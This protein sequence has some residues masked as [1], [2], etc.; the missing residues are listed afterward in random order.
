M[1]GI[2][3]E[4]GQ[5]MN[6]IAFDQLDAPVGPAAYRAGVAS[7]ATTLEYAMLVDS[8]KIVAAARMSWLASRR[9]AGIGVIPASRRRAADSTDCSNGRILPGDRDAGAGSSRRR[10]APS[11]CRSAT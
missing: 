8:D 3:A 9:C 11:P 4:L 1:C 10:R 2:D 7:I 5:A 6:E